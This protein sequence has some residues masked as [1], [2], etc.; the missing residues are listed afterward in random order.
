MVGWWGD[1][2]GAGVGCSDWVATGVCEWAKADSPCDRGG[3]FGDVRTADLGSD[4]E[5][6]RVTGDTEQIP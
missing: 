4:L 6:N 2:C 3:L 1:G 5:K